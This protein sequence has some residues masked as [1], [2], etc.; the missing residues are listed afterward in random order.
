[1]R[2][3]GAQLADAAFIEKLAQAQP[4]RRAADHEGFA[5]FDAG[6]RADV[7][8]RFG[9]G[10]SHAE[11]LF[12]EHVLAGFGGLGG[13]GDVKLIGQRIVD[14]V[15]V[16]V[17]EQFLVG[18][19]GRG[20]AERLRGRSRALARSR[21]AMAATVV[22][23]PRCMAGMTFLRPMLAVLSTPK[24]SFLHSGIIQRPGRGW[25]CNA[26]CKEREGE[27]R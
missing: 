4:L 11:R 22:S 21:E 2:G 1:M 12:A 23:S 17:G 13:P 7:E 3:D 5:D 8:Q 24:R 26:C 9:L 18:A 19:V 16:G 10:D 14:R 25:H 20:N 15:D 6:A 27:G